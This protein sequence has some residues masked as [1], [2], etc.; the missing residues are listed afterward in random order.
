MTAPNVNLL[1]QNHAR[2]A[3]NEKVS[4]VEE[5]AAKYVQ[6]VNELAQL[7][8]HDFI[9]AAIKNAARSMPKETT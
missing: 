4:E 5:L 6:T 3:V 9:R 8:A 1:I 2:D 7:M